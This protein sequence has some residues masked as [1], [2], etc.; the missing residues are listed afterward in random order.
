MI[1]VPPGIKTVLSLAKLQEDLCFEIRMLSR[2][3]SSWLSGISSRERAPN[4]AGLRGSGVGV[5]FCGV[6][7][8]WK[9]GACSS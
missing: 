8:V 2:V 6:V 5:L 1:F 4:T 3:R 9:S 7:D